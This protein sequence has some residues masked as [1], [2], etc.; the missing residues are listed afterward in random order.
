MCLEQLDK[1]EM[2]QHSFNH[3][4]NAI[5]QDAK[6]LSAK[7]KYMTQIISKAAKTELHPNNMN[8]EN[9]HVLRRSWKPLMCSLNEWRKPSCGDTWL[10]HSP[11]SSLSSVGSFL[12]LLPSFAPFS[13]FIFTV[14]L[15]CM[16]YPQLYPHHNTVS[17]TASLFQ[18]LCPHLPQLF[19]PCNLTPLDY[20]LRGSSKLLSN[21]SNY[22]QS[23]QHHTTDTFNLPE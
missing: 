8:R 20:P 16:F 14:L 6:I 3:E 15:S 5:P 4:H 18:L 7:S 11:S 21:T 17:P 2:A 9:N 23:M 10:Y 12:S 22:Y 13:H 19:L 1:S